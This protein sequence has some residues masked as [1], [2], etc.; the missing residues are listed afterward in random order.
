[1]NENKKKY[2]PSGKNGPSQFKLAGFPHEFERNFWDLFDRRYYSILLLTSLLLFGFT[3]WM[4]TR[5][6]E[7]TESQRQRIKQTYLEQIYAEIVP[8]EEGI[9]EGEGEGVGV[10]TGEEEGAE[11]EEKLSDESQKLVSESVSDKVERRRAGAGARQARRQQLEQEAAG[12]GVLAALTG[13]GGGGSGDLSYS[14]ILGEGGGGSGLENAGDLVSGTK[15]LETA[16]G[17]GQR[18]RMAKGGVGGEGG[19]AGID[20]LIEGSGGSGSGG[21]GT[22]VR[23]SGSIELAQ[24]TNVQ[25]SGASLAQRDPEVID[26]VI[27]KNKASVEYCYQSQLKVDPTLRGEVVLTFD[28]SPM[29]KVGAVKIVNSTLNNRK[30]EQCIIRSVRRWSNFPRLENS[31]GIVTIKTKFIFG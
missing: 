4:S 18:T 19:S 10:A 24:G 31:R 16:T 12:Q 17:S 15:S 5:N 13:G 27:N 7:M 26:A 22:E 23:R 6:W 8:S 11:E 3:I 21:S 14:D 20:D 30:V 28:I 29:G 25:G 1:M 2:I 9:I